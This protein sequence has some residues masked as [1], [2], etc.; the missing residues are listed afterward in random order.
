LISD[1]RRDAVVA[2]GKALRDAAKIEYLG[3]FAPGA[4]SA[5]EAASAPA[6]VASG[7]DAATLQKG[8]GIK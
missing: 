2:E 7:I 6:A 1:R 4:A 3:K 8:L 5:P